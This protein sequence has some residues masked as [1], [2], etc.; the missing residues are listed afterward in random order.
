[1]NRRASRT[2]GQTELTRL[3]INSGRL[4]HFILHGEN[5]FLAPAN[6]LRSGYVHSAPFE[7]YRLQSRN[8]IFFISTVVAGTL[9]RRVLESTYGR[10][11]AHTLRASCTCVPLIILS[12]TTSNLVH[13]FP[14][15]NVYES[16]GKICFCVLPYLVVRLNNPLHSI[17]QSLTNSVIKRQTVSHTYRSGWE[18]S[19]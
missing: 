18:C 11:H 17:F 4:L 6:R 19:Q 15:I 3:Y 5:R 1:M 13:L 9:A 12:R 8:G 10:A 2:A 14:Y 16:G 7:Q